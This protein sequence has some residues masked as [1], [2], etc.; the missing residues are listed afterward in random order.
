MY[1]Y[2]L[3]KAKGKER[4]GVGKQQGIKQLNGIKT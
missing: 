4:S 3:N 1:M 2:H